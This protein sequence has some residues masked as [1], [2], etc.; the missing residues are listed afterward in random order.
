MYYFLLFISALFAVARFVV[1]VEGRIE[2]AD[3]FKDVAHI[4]VG[5][6]FGVAG[7][8]SMLRRNSEWKDYKY[9]WWVLPIGLTI[10]EVIAFFVRKGG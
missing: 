1:P 9:N 5:V 8:I 7:A 4:W 2:P 10:I 3:I 6:L